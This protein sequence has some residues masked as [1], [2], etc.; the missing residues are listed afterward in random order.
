[1]TQYVSIIKHKLYSELKVKLHPDKIYIQHYSKGVNFI[2]ATIKKQRMYI[3]NR[4]VCNLYNTI[5]RFNDIGD[6]T[7][8]QIIHFFQSLNSYY[9]FL[10]HYFTFNIKLKMNRIINVLWESYFYISDNY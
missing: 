3:A 7:N 1:M 4:S 2:G 8:E 10:K 5:H 6:N 9:G